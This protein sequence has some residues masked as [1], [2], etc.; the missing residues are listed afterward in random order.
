MKQLKL[1]Y[2]NRPFI[3]LIFI[4]RAGTLKG[5]CIEEYGINNQ[6]TNN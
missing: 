5:N 6:I 1:F 3:Q 2:Y 4:L